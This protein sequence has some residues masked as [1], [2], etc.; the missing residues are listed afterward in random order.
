MNYWYFFNFPRAK[1]LYT[2]LTV[3]KMRLVFTK[4]WRYRKQRRAEIRDDMI[5]YTIVC[6]PRIRD[7][8]HEGVFNAI[9]AIPSSGRKLKVVYR[10]IGEQ[11]FKIITACWIR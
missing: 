9:C 4:H 6:S 2:H 1:Q 7:R 10:Q 3:F 11:T 5:E 8:T